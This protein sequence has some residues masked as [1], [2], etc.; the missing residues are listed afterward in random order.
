MS[1][2]RTGVIFFFPTNVVWPLH[3]SHRKP[4]TGTPEIYLGEL[5]TGKKI[6]LVKTPNGQTVSEYR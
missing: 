3:A 4:V 2:H 1:D 5:E 6:T